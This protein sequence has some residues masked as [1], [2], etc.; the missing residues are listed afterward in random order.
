[1]SEVF[2]KKTWVDRQSQ[3]PNRRR[4]TNV[5]TSEETVY[6]VAREEGTVDVAG[7][8][9]NASNMN[10]LEERIEDAVDTL[11]TNFQA[12]VDSIYDA[13][14]DKGSTP[15]SHSLADVVEAIENISGGGSIVNIFGT[16]TNDTP[17][18]AEILTRT[19]DIYSDYYAYEGFGDNEKG[20]VTQNRQDTLLYHFTDDSKYRPTRV[21]FCTNFSIFSGTVNDVGVT[22]AVS[23]NGSDWTTLCQ[24]VISPSREQPFV[25][26]LDIND[27]FS[28][29]QFVVTGGALFTG[30]K[31]IRCYGERES[32]GGGKGLD[33]TKNIFFAKS[34]VNANVVEI[35]GNGNGN[36]EQY[37]T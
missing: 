33:T 8:P 37:A 12:G 36:D 24:N 7:H 20:W 15:V 2:D 26:D 35:G 34:L 3:H 17:N 14:V 1:M 16:P 19:G 6:D 10:D 9:F 30:L 13:C 29:F 4:L 22:F 11:Q 25:L 5:S 32:G 28:Y 31:N 21:E 23:N 27:Y 18:N